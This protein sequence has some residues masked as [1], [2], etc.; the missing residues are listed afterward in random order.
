M[1]GKKGACDNIRLDTHV[2]KNF[3]QFLY[4]GSLKKW[5]NNVSKEVNRRNGKAQGVLAGF[6]VV[7]KST[8]L[9]LG[10]KLKILQTMSLCL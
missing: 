10:T 8:D 9:G 2:I 7:W 6:N 4:L 1:P 5:N 3:D